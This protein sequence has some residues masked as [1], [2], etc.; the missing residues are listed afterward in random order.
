MIQTLLSIQLNSDIIGSLKAVKY[1][2]SH[3]GHTEH[4]EVPL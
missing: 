1:L 2:G 4:L 3:H